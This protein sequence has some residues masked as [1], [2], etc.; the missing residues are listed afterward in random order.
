MEDQSAPKNEY[1]EK[2]EA[3]SNE[4]KRLSMETHQRHLEVRAGFYEKLAAI[5]A[6]SIAVVVSVGIAL[7][8]RTDSITASS[9]ARLGWLV[10]IATFLWLSLVVSIAHNLIYVEITR[11]QAE[12]AQ[13]G[14]FI[15]SYLTGALAAHLSG[16]EQRIKVM[17]GLMKHS[18]SERLTKVTKKTLRLVFSMKFVR[19]IG[20]AATTS[21]L[22]AYTLA[23]CWF[24]RIWWLSR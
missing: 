23:F 8:G 19:V 12:V 14:S 10:A 16:S 18:F 2:L 5:S 4:A 21:F 6:G 17:D 22:I 9:H 20:Y 15:Q 24:F 13:E 11:L 3:S 1:L 7:A